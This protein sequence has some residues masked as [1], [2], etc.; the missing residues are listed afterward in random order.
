MGTYGKFKFFIDNLSFITYHISYIC[1]RKFA[2]STKSFILNKIFVE[3][4][5]DSLIFEN[6]LVIIAR[7]RIF[8]YYFI[9]PFRLQYSGEFQLFD[10]VIENNATIISDDYD[11][12]I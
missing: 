5:I 6:Y 10:R 11:F 8:R 2:F 1:V 3:N 12:Y 9:T 7:D 4:Y